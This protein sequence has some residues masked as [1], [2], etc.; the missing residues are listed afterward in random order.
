MAPLLHR[1]AI[2]NKASLVASYDIWL[3]NGEGLFLFWHFRNLS[4]TYLLHLPTNLQPRPHMGQS[5]I[6]TKSSYTDDT[7]A[8]YSTCWSNKCPDEATFSWQPAAVTFNN[9]WSQSMGYNDRHPFNGLFFQD[10]LG[11]PATNRLD[12]MTRGIKPDIA[13]L[14]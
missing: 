10:N 7:Y 12:A 1:A 9:I 4:L 8:Y 13:C 6:N 14:Q 2:K 5:V 3:G 11:K